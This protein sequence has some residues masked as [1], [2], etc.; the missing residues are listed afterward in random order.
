MARFINHY[1]CPN[2]QL[3]AFQR[4]V[5]LKCWNWIFPVPDEWAD[6]W[7]CTCDDDCPECGFR[8][9]SPVESEDGTSGQDRESYSDDQDRKNYSIADD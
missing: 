7:D 8:H 4:L 1:R 3:P 6:E 2:C 9:V 5:R